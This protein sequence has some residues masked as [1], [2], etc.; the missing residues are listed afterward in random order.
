MKMKVILPLFALFLLTAISYRQDVYIHDDLTKSWET[1]A[2]MDVPESVLL[3]RDNGIIYIANISG[4]PTEK[5]EK[6]FITKM[7]STGTMA[8]IKWTEGLH[9]PKGMG[10]FDDKLYVSD[11]DRVAEIDTKTGKVT[12]FYDAP[13][14]IFLNDI[15]IDDEGT[16]Y[17]S[18]MKDQ[19]IY[20][21]KDGSL[22]LWLQSDK[23]D[24]PNGLFVFEDKL[25]A[26]I[27]GAV[28]K[29]DP[30]T[31]SITPYIENTGSIDGLKWVE[32]ETF[33]ISDWKGA[34]HLISPDNEKIKLLDTTEAEINAADIDFCP[35]S[36]TLFVPTFFDN[37]VMVYKLK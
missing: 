24:N 35:T 22:E 4:N 6:G 17:I 36:R 34:V 7:S 29:I 3:D 31:K 2:N 14:A 11:I 1:E 27:N 28:L 23:L 16:V 8:K 5:N 21:L 18:D 20:R 37:R 10:L 33:I 19:A 30:T 32:D 26:G 25:L 9:A 13:D 12:A 15:S